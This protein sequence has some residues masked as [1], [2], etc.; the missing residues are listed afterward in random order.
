MNDRKASRASQ[1]CGE[2]CEAEDTEE[3]FW[4]RLNDDVQSRIKLGNLLAG[5]YR[6]YD[7][8]KMFESALASKPHDP[9]LWLKLG[10]ARL[11]LLDFDGAHAAYKKAQ[12]YGAGER[13]LGYALG[14][15]HY[16]KGEYGEAVNRFETCRPCDGETEIALLYWIDL[17]RMRSGEA[18]FPPEKRQIITDFG[19]HAAYARS[20]A[21]LDGTVTAEGLEADLTGYN[22]LDRVIAGYAL[23]RFL[24]FRR[25]DRRAG[26]VLGQILDAESVWPCISGLA[27]WND[28][29]NEK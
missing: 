21:L 15:R 7:A 6:F 9:S 19:H 4:L 3:M 26:K 12:E 13:S 10:G 24:L 23:Y 20:V 27:A 17:C 2:I 29:C 28:F 25:E 18:P 11:T 16:L 1:L 8:A 14:I 22:D 5:Q